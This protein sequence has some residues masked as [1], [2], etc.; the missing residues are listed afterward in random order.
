L[1]E[2]LKH[3]WE[4]E[5]W[6]MKNLGGLPKVRRSG[7]IL[8]KM[9][10]VREAVRERLLS[11]SDEERAAIVYVPGPFSSEEGDPWTIRKAIRRCLE[12]QWEHLDEIS[13]RVGGDRADEP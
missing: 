1:R 2:I 5:Q 12:H 9:A 13:Q 11:L 10:A 4:A 3:V 8:V 7:D 6:Y